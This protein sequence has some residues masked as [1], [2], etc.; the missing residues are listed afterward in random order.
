M[1]IGCSGGPV[2]LKCKGSVRVSH[3]YLGRDFALVLQ[4][5][6]SLTYHPSLAKYTHSCL[7]DLI[8][9]VISLARLPLLTYR[10]KSRRLG[11]L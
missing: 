10:R 11:E 6:R 5:Q 2:Q 7:A 3:C 1:L 9:A 8:D 4:S